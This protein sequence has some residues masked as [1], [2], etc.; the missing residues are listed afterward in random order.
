MT[1]NYKS[2]FNKNTKSI[3]QTPS[4]NQPHISNIHASTRNISRPLRN[5]N[6]HKNPEIFPQNDHLWTKALTEKPVHSR[7]IKNSKLFYNMGWTTQNQLQN[8]SKISMGTR[9]YFL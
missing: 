2:I 8:K 9:R 7:V 4:S 5:T 1:Q 6:V 3:L